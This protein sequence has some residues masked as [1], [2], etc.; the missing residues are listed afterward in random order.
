[1]DVRSPIVLDCP[2]TTDAPV[3]AF[4][5]QQVSDKVWEAADLVSDFCTAK[6]TADTAGE[7]LALEG[8]VC[9]FENLFR[10]LDHLD[11]RFEADVPCGIA[12][13]PVG[14]DG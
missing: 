3:P 11:P 5:L 12:L 13:R 10:A 9:A 2:I 4:P 7:Y 8:L 6:G 1:M 14:A